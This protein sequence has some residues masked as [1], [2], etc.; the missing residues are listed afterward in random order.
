MNPAPLQTNKQIM[1]QYGKSFRPT[2]EN[3]YTLAEEE[4]FKTLFERKFS[5]VELRKNPI[6]YR[7]DFSVLDRQSEKI[8]AMVE[9]RSRRYT[10]NK[11][12][13]FGGVKISL[14]KI[15]TGIEMSEKMGIPV[16]VFFKFMDT[17]RGEYYRFLMTRENYDRCGT[18]W[19]MLTSRNDPQDCE[20]VVTI[21]IAVLDHK[22]LNL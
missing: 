18:G 17:P 12:D 20:P 22:S 10:K 9:Y 11:I 15:L 21:P 8:I 6:Q 14:M 16:Q 3:K 4:D 5:D 13:E 2:Y 1:N 7:M 19:M